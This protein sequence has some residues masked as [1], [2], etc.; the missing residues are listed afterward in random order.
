MIYATNEKYGNYN[1]YYLECNNVLL[2]YVLLGTLEAKYKYL[3]TEYISAIYIYSHNIFMCVWEV[4]ER[5]WSC[6]CN[7]IGVSR[8]RVIQIT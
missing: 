5:G 3:K 6:K 1:V 2:T 7:K 8:V 4:I